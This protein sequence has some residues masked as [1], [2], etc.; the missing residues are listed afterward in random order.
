MYLQSTAYNCV[1]HT[2]DHPTT[3]TTNH[4][5][6]DNHNENLLK[7]KAA[8]QHYVSMQMGD[9]EDFDQKSKDLTQGNRLVYM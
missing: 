8:G 6:I 3:S 1:S 9:T 4:N 7:H 2:V 5:T